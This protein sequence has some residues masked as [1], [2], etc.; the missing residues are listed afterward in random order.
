MKQTLLLL[1]SILTF[2]IAVEAQPAIL[3]DINSEYCPNTVITFTVTF[4]G[5]SPSVVGKALNAAPSVVQQAYNIN[6]TNG[7]TTFNFDGRFIDANNKQTFQLNYKYGP[8][9]RDT[10]KDFTFIKI[11]SLTTPG[12]GSPNDCSAIK[13]TPTSITA[14]RCQT[15]SVTINFS[16]I[17]YS[18]VWENPIVCYGSVINYEYLLP[19]GWSIG[20]NVSNGTDW[21]EAGN[22]VTINYNASNGHQGSVRIRPVN[23]GCGANLNKGRIV[24]IPISRP[25]PTLSISGNDVICS[26]TSNYTVAGS[27]PPGATICWTI[28]SPGGAV[29]IPSSP[30]CGT[31]L[32][33]TYISV[34]TATIFA[35]VTDCIESYTLSQKDIVAGTP[36]VDRFIVDGD[37]FDYSVN[38]PNSSYTVCPS[39]GLTIY[40]NIP[41]GTQ[42]TIGVLEHDWQYVSGTYQIF[43]GGNTAA[44]YVYTSAS[45]GATLQ[46]RYRYRNACGWSG[47]DNVYFTNMN[48]DGGEEPYRVGGEEFDFTISPNPAKSL[49]I[50]NT[51]GITNNYEVRVIDMMNSKVVKLVQCDKSQKQVRLQI[52]D[53]NQGNYLIQI[54]CNGKT[55]TKQLQV[56]K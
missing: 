28:S 33:V 9:N 7:V 34:G 24:D 35:T 37:R 38:G 43:Q 55:K 26:G 52:A 22:N 36:A 40:P 12:N 6:T 14:P 49:A 1:L 54:I 11:K 42:G 50:I 32:P 56:T 44:A 27:L 46:L 16:N 45:V 41:I 5:N 3:P 10:T 18:N 21:I 19:S 47:Y 17:Q 4:A 20:T 25:R 51:K 39:E 23:T 15:G 2:Y 31:S 8:N 13:P 29:T 53:L 48:C 30:Y